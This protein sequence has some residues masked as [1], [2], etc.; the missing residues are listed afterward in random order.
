ME[1]RGP[2]AAWVWAGGGAQSPEGHRLRELVAAP[3][4]GYIAEDT[5]YAKEASLRA[6][7]RVPGGLRSLKLVNCPGAPGASLFSKACRQTAAHHRGTAD[8]CVEL[9]V[10]HG[11]MVHFFFSSEEAG[12]WLDTLPQSLDFGCPQ[13]DRDSS[14]VECQ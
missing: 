5:K 11:S 10:Q 9:R 14:T 13:R 4:P 12:D 8:V 2:R 3:G 1:A 6:R 7:T